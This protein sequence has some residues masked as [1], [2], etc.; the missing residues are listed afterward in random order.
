[1]TGINPQTGQYLRTAR[2]Y[3]AEER[4]YFQHPPSVPITGQ[5]Y[6]ED[7]ADMFMA[8]ALNNFTDDKAGRLRYEWMDNFVKSIFNQSKRWQNQSLKKHYYF[9]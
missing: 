7:F 4:P 1:V 6:Q 9:R 3:P 2:G 5:T 8:W